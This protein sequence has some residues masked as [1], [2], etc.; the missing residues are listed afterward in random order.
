MSEI[1]RVFGRMGGSQIA[2]GE[3]HEQVR[4]QRRGSSGVG[5][6]EVMRLTSKG[7]AGG[8]SSPPRRDPMVRAQTWEEGFPAKAARASLYLSLLSTISYPIGPEKVAP[9]TKIV[10]RIGDAFFRDVMS[11]T[12]K[13][14]PAL[15][16]VID[17]HITEDQLN[18]F[19]AAINQG[20]FVFIP[21]QNSEHCIGDVRNKRFRLSYLLCPRYKLPLMYGQRVALSRLLASNQSDDNEQ[22]QMADLF[23]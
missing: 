9:F 11:E 3:L 13:T 18:A 2:S 12:F 7:G 15:S 21:S 16:F 8:Q 6:G 20:A 4:I 14:E 19:G 10:D 23:R 22:Y 17:H 1:D 5:V